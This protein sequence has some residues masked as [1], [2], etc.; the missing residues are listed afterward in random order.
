MTV[1]KSSQVRSFCTTAEHVAGLLPRMVSA[2]ILKPAEA[3]L[4]VK[5]LRAGVEVTLDVAKGMETG[6]RQNA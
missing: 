6:E 2:K 4:L 5:Q 3:E 1:P